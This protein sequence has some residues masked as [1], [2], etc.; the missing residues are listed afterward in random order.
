MEPHGIGAPVVRKEG[1]DKVTGRA[2][3]VDDEVLP[4]MLHGVTIRTPCAR[5]SIRGL[6]FAPHIPWDEFIVV[7]AKDIPGL[8]AVA[9]LTEDQPYLA[10]E[11]FQHAEEPVAL[12]AHADKLLLEEARRAV[13]IEIEPLTPIFEM[14]DSDK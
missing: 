7:T 13:T 12:L 10:E 14:E 2:I 1:R 5:G 6:M 11:F 3:Y 9:L 4:G 8:N